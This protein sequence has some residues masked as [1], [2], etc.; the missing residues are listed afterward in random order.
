MIFCGFILFDTYAIMH[1][2]STEDYIIAAIDLYLDF[3]N[4]FI[5][6]L[7]ILDALKNK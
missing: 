5:Y 7:R 3:I 2:L 1:R 6:V 4:L